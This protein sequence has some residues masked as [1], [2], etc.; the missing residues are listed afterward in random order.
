L[1]CVVCVSFKKK[2]EGKP[3]PK[4]QSNKANKATEQNKYRLGIGLLRF[5]FG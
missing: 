3:N 5:V 2:K 1:C 4:K